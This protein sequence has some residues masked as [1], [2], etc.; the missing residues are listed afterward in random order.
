MNSLAVRVVAF[1]GLTMLMTGLLAI[2][3]L[4]ITPDTAVAEARAH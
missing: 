3:Y 1:A 4:T 2:P